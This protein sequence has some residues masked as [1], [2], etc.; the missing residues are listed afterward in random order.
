[1]FRPPNFVVRIF[2]PEIENDSGKEVTTSQNL[3]SRTGIRY[4]MRLQQGRGE[5]SLSET[6]GQACL[7]IAADGHFLLHLTRVPS[8]DCSCM[9]L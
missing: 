5:W 1:M 3:H 4:S 7:L 2:S 8:V 9:F 6:L